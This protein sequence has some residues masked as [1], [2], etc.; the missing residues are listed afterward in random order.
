MYRKN[1]KYYI[2]VVLSSI[3]SRHCVS[4]RETRKKYKNKNTS[5][6]VFS[7]LSPFLQSFSFSQMPNKEMFNKMLSL[8]LLITLL[9][10]KFSSSFYDSL[11]HM[12][13]K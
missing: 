8:L 11:K 6:L 7:P 3:R 1:N 10:L 2:G 13:I 9:K 12:H 4:E 5:Q